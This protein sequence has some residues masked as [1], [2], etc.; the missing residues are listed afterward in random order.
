MAVESVHRDTGHR[1][2]GQI[3]DTR[4]R[5]P[6]STRTRAY[7]QLN[8]GVYISWQYLSSSAHMTL[9][10]TFKGH[11]LINFTLPVTQYINWFAPSKGTIYQVPTCDFSVN[12]VNSRGC[13][14]N[15]VDTFVRG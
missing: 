9:V 4:M 10:F 7:T 5:F 13:P 2:D 12:T 15:H 14:P 6:L 3:P 8:P 1:P 11:V